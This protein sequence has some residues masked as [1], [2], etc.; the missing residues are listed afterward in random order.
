MAEYVP[1]YIY[2]FAHNRG[3]F[4]GIQL[5][6]INQTF[7]KF[8]KIPCISHK[9]ASCEGSLQWCNLEAIKNDYE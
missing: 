8:V 9:N 2:Q 4:S 7:G 3:D 6:D 5:F 1:V